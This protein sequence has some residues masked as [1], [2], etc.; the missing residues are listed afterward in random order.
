M[1]S[2]YSGVALMCLMML[3]AS[4]GS[5]GPV[6]GSG[7]EGS[8][9]R[10]KITVQFPANAGAAALALARPVTL[11]AS[12]GSSLAELCRVLSRESGLRIE[13]ARDLADEKLLVI[14]F[15]LPL[16]VLLH[17]LSTLLN[18]T[19]HRSSDAGVSRY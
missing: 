14:G 9:G 8:R 3:V 2:S 4:A 17:R 18:A 6:Q 16:S 10:S 15:D 1:R 5:A 12:R 7:D 11:H 13:P 19:L